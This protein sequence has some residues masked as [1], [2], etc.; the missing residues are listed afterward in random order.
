VHYQ[1]CFRYEDKKGE[2]GSFVV[3]EDTRISNHTNSELSTTIFSWIVDT[4]IIIKNKITLFPVS[5]PSS[6]AVKDFLKQEFKLCK[7]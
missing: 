4:L 1:T 5:P 6:K 3:F 7:W 2:E